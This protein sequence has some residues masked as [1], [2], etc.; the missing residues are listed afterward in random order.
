LE[1]TLYWD[2]LRKIKIITLLL[3]VFLSCNKSKNTIEGT[4]AY[5]NTVEKG[6][7]N[8]SSQQ[9]RTSLV[10]RFEKGEIK[11]FNNNKRYGIGLYFYK[12]KGDSI[13]LTNVQVDTTGRFD[14]LGR[15]GALLSIRNDTMSIKEGDKTSFY[16]RQ[17][18]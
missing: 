14:T 4:W 10:Q 18:D 16:I 9:V 3:I 11:Y 15:F 13:F 1:A 2:W 6:N 8:G 5:I 7:E 17:K 12:L